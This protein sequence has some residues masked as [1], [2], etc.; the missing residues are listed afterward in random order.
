[1]KKT[2]GS[3]KSDLTLSFLG[4]S[5]FLSFIAMILAIGIVFFVLDATSFNSLIGKNLS[6]DFLNNPVLMFGTL[7]LTVGIGLISGLYPALYL[8]TIPTIKALK[9]AFKNQTSSLVLRKVLITAQFAISIFVEIGRAH[10]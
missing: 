1:M 3:S 8:P 4:E 7:A 9:G 10:V 6:A 2:L 5:V